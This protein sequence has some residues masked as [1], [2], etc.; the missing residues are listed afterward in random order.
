MEENTIVSSWT[1][2]PL[3]PT[4]LPTSSHTHAHTH[5][6]TPEDYLTKLQPSMVCLS[7]RFCSTWFAIVCCGGWMRSAEACL[8]C[9]S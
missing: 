8:P 4:K 5:T 2:I 3:S 6:Q 7:Q 1:D 9:C